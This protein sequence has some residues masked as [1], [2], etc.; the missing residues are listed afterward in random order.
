MSGVLLCGLGEPLTLGIAMGI[1]CRNVSCS[2]VSFASAC[3]CRIQSFRGPLSSWGAKKFQDRRRVAESAGSE[4]L[5][6]L[7]CDPC[8]RTNRAS[9]SNHAVSDL[10]RLRLLASSCYTS[11][12]VKILPD[13]CR[14]HDWLGAAS[15]APRDDMELN[16]LTGRYVLQQLWFRLKLL[17]LHCFLS[18]PHFTLLST[19]GEGR[20]REA[21]WP[22]SSLTTL[23]LTVKQRCI[24]PRFPTS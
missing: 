8:R 18:L 4:T 23:V 14:L 19:S 7:P 13:H 11:L 15:T 21:P 2:R 1:R 9:V 24:R 5:D 3:A 10:F 17:V 20:G 12:A 22:W 6:P 16:P